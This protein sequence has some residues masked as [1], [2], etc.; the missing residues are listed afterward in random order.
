MTPA[1]SGDQA[2]KVILFLEECQHSRCRKFA[3]LQRCVHL[4]RTLAGS[5]LVLEVVDGV[6][7]TLADSALQSYQ[8]P[9]FLQIQ[10]AFWQQKHTVLLLCWALT[11]FSRKTSQS[12]SVEASSTTISR[13]LSE[14]LKMMNLDFLANLR[15]LNAFMHSCETEALEQV[16]VSIVDHCFVRRVRDQVL[17]LLSLDFFNRRFSCSGKGDW[18]DH[19]IGDD[20]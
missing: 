14:S 17:L 16:Y 10:V 19:A 15:S 12:P 3:D 1:S 9:V 2:M 4:P 18:V 11:S 6:T 20:A 5:K 7:G 13:L 8:H